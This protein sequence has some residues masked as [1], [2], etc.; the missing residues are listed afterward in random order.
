MSNL[1]STKLI[2][3]SLVSVAEFRDS[4]RTKVVPSGVSLKYK[5]PGGTTTVATATL[6]A[7]TSSYKA[8]VLLDQAGIWNFRWECTGSYASAEEFEIQVLPSKV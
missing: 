1:T 5:P 7:P 8:T 6:D 2:G 3:S 4:A